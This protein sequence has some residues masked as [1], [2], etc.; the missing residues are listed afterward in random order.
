MI[1][2]RFCSNTLRRGLVLFVVLLLALPWSALASSVDESIV[3]ATAPTGSVTLAPGASA[4]I[5]INLSVTGQ[6]VGT[7]T[8]DVYRDWTLSGGAFTGANPQ[9]FTVSP[10]AATDPA[11]TFSTTGTVT[12]DSGQAAGTFTLAVGAFDITNTNTTGAKLSAGSSSNYQVTVQAPTDTT[13]PT[14]NCGQPDGIWHADNV[15]IACTASDSSGLQNPI[16]ASFNLTTNVPAGAETDNA[17]TDSRQVCDTLNNCITA[18]PISGNKVDRKAP[19]ITIGTPSNGVSYLLNQVVAASYGCTD[20]GSGVATCA[21][22]VPSGSNVDTGSVGSKTFTVNASDN[23]GNA[24][25]STV[26]YSVNYN[27][28]LLFDNT[29]PAK[30]GSTL[31]IKLQLCDA[32]NANASSSGIVVTATSITQVSAS[33]DGALQDSG[34]ANPDNNFRYD[35]TLGG[36]GGYIYNLSTKG[37]GTGTYKMVFTTSNGGSGEITFAVK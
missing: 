2:K 25:T 17:S 13:P 19:S 33:T 32:N 24:S 7:A 18:G 28:C 35:P 11:T 26:T 22:P 37:Y 3:D 10:R 9:T 5:T 29:R 4:S 30:A 6:Q 14:I 1:V 36:T 16:D 12:V 20:G 8:F 21:G 23:V 31:P 34:N 15:S 27:V